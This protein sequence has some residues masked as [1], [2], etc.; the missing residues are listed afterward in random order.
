MPL[1]IGRREA[2]RTVQAGERTYHVVTD[3]VFHDQLV[4]AGRL[5]DR[6]SGETWQ[7][8]FRL[9][10]AAGDRLR[11]RVGRDG[12]FAVAADPQLAFPLLAAQPYPLTLE[13]SV[14]GFRPL[15]RILTLA[16]GTVFPLPQ[17]TIP[18]DRL[19]ITLAGRVVEAGGAGPPIEG[20]LVRFTS[21]RSL[22]LRTPLHRDHP[23]GTEVRAVGLTAAGAAREL[24]A[25]A[26]RTATR[27][28]LSSRT[29]LAAGDVLR[30]GEERRWELAVVA[31]LPPLPAD[32][33][34]PGEVV[35][36]SPLARSFVAATT[37]QPVTVTDQAA[38]AQLDA[39]VYAGGGV[40]TL[41]APVAAAAVRL[42]PA[43]HP[44]REIHAVGALSDADGFFQVDGVD[45]PGSAV[46]RA[47]AA[48]F[49]PG[50][51][52]WV[53]DFRAGIHRL[54]FALAT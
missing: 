17:L 51:V 34:L 31:E 1:E 38:V 33:A 2:R 44:L 11:S 42:R 16:A 29:G 6:L 41:D 10:A 49:L 15:T 26:P 32:P 13:I 21:A 43:G 52:D 3:L 12:F 23:A 27:L 20:A 54:D 48:G 40:L 47:T 8:P 7:G 19:P 36:G 25:P 9:T 45:R 4:V 28:L 53:P 35:L 14:A 30:V 50:E 18:L 24:D 22:L 5:V 46:V 37:V 39:A